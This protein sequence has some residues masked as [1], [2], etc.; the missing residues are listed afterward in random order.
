[1]CTS[2]ANIGEGKILLVGLTTD[3]ISTV[4]KTINISKLHLHWKEK[5]VIQLVH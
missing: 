1:M 2:V 5:Y 3:G 4:T